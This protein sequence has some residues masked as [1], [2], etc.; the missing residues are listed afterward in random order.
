VVQ[1]SSGARE[2]YA[3][4]TGGTVASWGYNANGQLG[5]GTTTDSTTPVQVSGLTGVSSISCG[6]SHV[7]ARLTNGTLK[8]WGDNG[9]GQLGN[10]SWDDSS[11]PGDVTSLSTAGSVVYCSTGAGSSYAVKTDGTVVSWGYNEYGQLGTGTTTF[12]TEPQATQGLS[13][14]TQISGG[15]EHTVAL[16]NDGTVWSFGRNNYGQLGGFVGD[17]STIAVQSQIEAAG[18]IHFAN[19]NYTVNIP[20]SGNATITVSASGTDEN[21]DPIDPTEI[22]Y[23]LGN[24]Y[25]GISIDGQT[26]VIT[27]TTAA[28]AGSVNIIATCGELT[29]TA[30][31]NVTSQDSTELTLSVDINST[32]FVTLVANSI[33]SFSGSSFTVTYDAD[34]L[35]LT[36]LCALTYGHETVVG[37]IPGTGITVTSYSPGQI[38]FTVD[39]TIPTGNKWSGVVNTIKFV[40][41]TNT[42]TTIIL[43]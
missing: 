30:L 7:L 21:G 17:S 39:K 41:L 34:V 31:L 42:N 35:Q 26:G 13:G 6:D 15:L 4:L 25:T 20:T 27:I 12:Y 38:Q 8:A 11:T 1:I 3:V 22:S 32:Y 40:A 2:G 43:N 9:A 29:C 33:T 23:T 19:N 14:I 18:S 37:T 10:G 5:D 16:K 36:D 24:S 28:A